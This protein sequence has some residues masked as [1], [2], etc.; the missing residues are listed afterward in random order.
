MSWF[1][2][3]FGG[4]C[5]YSFGILFCHH[6]SW[7]WG[8]GILLASCS[9]INSWFWLG[10]GSLCPY[11]FGILFHPHLTWFWLEGSRA[12]PLLF[13]HPVL[14]SFPG[15]LCPYSLA[16]CSRFW[17]GFRGLIPTLLPSCS[18]ILSA[19]VLVLF[20]RLPSS[21]P[22][23]G[24]GSGACAPTLLASCSVIISWF[25]GCGARVPY[26]LGIRFRHHFLVLARVPGLRPCSFGILFCHHFLVACAPTL[27]RPVPGSG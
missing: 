26:S 10:F 1:R 17:L 7:F 18:V 23:C 6:F 24:L 2:L 19:G 14:S 13:W 25:W 27:W 12:S 3:G 9:I 22:G 20:W 21:F 16:S 8:S 15:G 4:F 5:P 11:S